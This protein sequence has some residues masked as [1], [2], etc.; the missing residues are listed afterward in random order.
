MIS[1]RF[2]I[3]MLEMDRDVVQTQKI[4]WK[5]RVRFMGG[6]T[7]HTLVAHML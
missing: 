2:T 5:H 7:P 6:S 4:K 1:Q 3:K